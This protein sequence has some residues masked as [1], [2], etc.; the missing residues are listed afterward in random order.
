MNAESDGKCPR[1][2]FE[3]LKECARIIDLKIC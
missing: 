2:E 1:H 3:L